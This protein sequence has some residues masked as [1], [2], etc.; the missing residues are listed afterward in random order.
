ML[1]LPPYN[2][3]PLHITFFNVDAIREWAEAAAS[4]PSSDLPRGFTVTVELEGVDGKSTRPVLPSSSSGISRPVR[5]MPIDVKDCEPRGFH[6]SALLHSYITGSTIHRKSS[7][8][9]ARTHRE[10]WRR[11]PLLRLH[12]DHK[13]HNRCMLKPV[14][15]RDP[16]TNVSIRSRT[17]S[18]LR[19]APTPLVLALRICCA[20]PPHS[21]LP[22]HLRPHHPASSQGEGSVHHVAN[23]R[24]GET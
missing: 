21:S 12:E 10:E 2:S 8:Q 22:H 6:M 7:C 18:V 24:Y 5:T 16:W 14:S 3:W 23:T 17:L 4:V 13:C 1:S 11:A 19:S 20:F 15:R 9:A